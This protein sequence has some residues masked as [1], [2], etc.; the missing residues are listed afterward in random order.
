VNACD[1]LVAALR[2]AGIA[3]GDGQA[4]VGA[5]PLTGR[6]VVVWPV[7]H[8]RGPG[9]I[10][11][12]N[13][14][15]T[16]DLQIT[17]VGPS[18]GAADQVAEAARAVALGDLEPPDGFAWM[19]APEYVVGNPTQQETSAGPAAPEAPVWSRADIYRYYLT[20]A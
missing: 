13:P 20:P 1:R 14:D 7:L 6:Y 4:R 2:A 17:S 8:G 9:T 16:E 5:E 18:R 15:R 12:P 11:D 3:T 19:C 10:A